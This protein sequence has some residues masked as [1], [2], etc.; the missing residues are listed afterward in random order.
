MA[1]LT[2]PDC[3][4]QVGPG[5]LICFTCGANLPRIQAVPDEPLPI[6]VAQKAMSAERARLISSTVLRISFPAGNVE[7]P[8]GTSVLLG[9]DPAESL[10]A[11]AFDGCDNVSRRHAL[12]TVDDSGRATIRDEGSTN[13]T[14]VNGDRLLPGIEVRLV[15]GDTIRLA[16]DVTGE[17]A[18]PH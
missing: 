3:S 13:G 7:V 9:R 4:A 5:D 18:L 6:T 8:A 10:V 2:C 11:A 12:I 14:F 16:A 17:V 15:D 1:T